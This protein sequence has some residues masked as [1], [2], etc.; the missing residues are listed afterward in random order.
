MKKYILL[1]IFLFF[2]L[3]N[4]AG[5]TNSCV[6]LAKDLKLRSFDSTGKNDV[7]TLQ[8]FLKEKSFLMVNP[9]GYFGAQTLKAVKDFQKANNI[10]PTGYVG[11]LTRSLIKKITCIENTTVNT[12]NTSSAV[13]NTNNTNT[14]QI[15]TTTTT[16]ENT[17]QNTQTST[18]TS[19]TSDEVIVN[20]S[21]SLRVRT[22]GATNIGKNSVTARGEVT[23]GARSGTE[24]WLEMTKNIEN[25]KVSETLMSAKSSNKTNTK[26]ESTI[27]NL[28]PN[29]TYYFRSCAGNVALGQRTCGTTSSLKTLSQ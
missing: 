21:S 24:V 11:P 4:T 10:N 25:F 20:S 5:A 18:N 2:F 13:S 16:T 15:N 29:T 14:E 9:S 17:V 23:A 12:E 3:F 27:N 1:P 19:T 6:D 7:F 8:S 22:L 26:F 28:E